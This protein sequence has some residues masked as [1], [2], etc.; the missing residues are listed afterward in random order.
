[1]RVEIIS[2]G[3]ELLNGRVVDTNARFLR[4]EIKRVG[5]SLKLV[6]MVGDEDGYIEAVLAAS[7]SR[8]DI[9]LMTGGLGATHDDLTK[10]CVSK[11]LNRK[12]VLSA[13][14]LDT[15]KK[16]F[17][18]N[19]VDIPASEQK[20]ALL[21]RRCMVVPNRYGTAPGFIC[22]EEQV[23]IVC[24]PGVPKEMEQMWTDE[25]APYLAERFCKNDQKVTLF[26]RTCGL[27]EMEVNDLLAGM[28]AQEGISVNLIARNGGVDI[29]FTMMPDRHNPVEVTVARIK[30]EVEKLLGAS[31]YAWKEQCLEEI[32]GR[33]L[34]S[35]SLTL[36]IAESCTGGLISHLV[37]Q[38]PGSS[39]YFERGLVTY[40]N[41]AKQ[42]LLG[43]S[44]DTL[45]Q[46][47]AVSSQT[48]REMAKGVR[49]RADTDIGLGVTGIAGPGG[50]SEEKPAG[51]V[52]VALASRKEC[53]CHSFR[54]T[55]TRETVKMRSAMVSLNMLRQYLETGY[56]R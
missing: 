18:Q 9:I 8:S 25:V 37:T 15:L 22:Q 5:H 17:E 3:T 42:E 31:L 45:E 6:T 26:A 7:M 49:E 52:Y 47:G 2:I 21:P 24:L 44:A 43:V 46:H 38:V 50:G 20:Q 54:F 13:E 55:G 29:G 48:A 51:L 10:R 23:V 14:V 36:G 32:V 35:K 28:D 30:M 19:Q 1:M 12:L 41:Q 56:V 53:L 11:V 34:A 27:R 39:A 4:D 40:S 16:R 33:L